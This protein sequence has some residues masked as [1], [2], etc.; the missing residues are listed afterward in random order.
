MRRHQCRVVIAA[1]LPLSPGAA[2]PPFGGKKIALSS[3]T[4][5]VKPST[6][7]TRTAG[8]LEIEPYLSLANRVLPAGP[9]PRCR[10][11]WHQLA[12]SFAAEHGLYFPDLLSRGKGHDRTRPDIIGLSAFIEHSSEHSVAQGAA[13]PPERRLDSWKEIAAFFGRDERTVRRWEKESALPVHRV[14]GGAKGRVFAYASELDLW[15]S[16]P[17]AQQSTTPEP[18]PLLDP[19][20]FNSTQTTNNQVSELEVG[21]IQTRPDPKAEA[22]R[23]PRRYATAA[24]GVAALA[25]CAAL[26]AGIWAYRKNH[27]FA[28]YA[29][30]PGISRVN[31]ALPT[32]SGSE[33]PSPGPDSIA[34]LPF[35]NA[36]ADS[37]TDYL[38]D[39]I[40]ESLIGSL[41]RLPQLKIRSRDSV[42]RYNG[43]DVD[44]Q[45]AGRN[46]NVSALVSGRVVMQRDIVEISAELTDVRNNTELWGHRYTGK[47]A[48]LISLQ[49]QMAGDIAAKLRSTLSAADKEQV[50]NQGTQNAEAYSLYLKGRY[51]WNNRTRPEL[52]KSISYFNQAIARD[53][54]YAL[55]YV[56]L[57]DTYAVL[58]FFNVDPR[59]TFPKSNVA[60]RKALELDSTLAHP[61]AVLGSN[62]MEY[63][64]DFAGGESEFKKS[65]ELDPNDATAHQWYAEKLSL[66]GRHEEAIAEIN[67]AH[68]LDPE[69]LVI[70]RVIGG[71]L[72]DARQYD[73]AIAVCKQLTQD[74]P[75]FAIG[76]DCLF[77]AYW[78]KRMYPQAVEEW[79]AVGQL[80]NNP[81]ASENGNALDHGFHAGGWR[82]AL[83]EV[84]A[85][86]QNRRNH[87]G[88]ASPFEIARF[89]ADRGEREKAFEWLDIAYRE[90]DCLLI[91]LNMSFQFDSIRSD[92]RF[93][94]LVHKVGL[95]Q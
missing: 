71:T 3:I 8:I 6:T 30:G 62:E 82:Q 10:C 93:A 70:D 81:D 2:W 84:I 29:S 76:H 48:D 57:A 21:E 5:I 85:A 95:P 78:A 27:R 86:Q 33:S 90:H 43:K 12:I 53:P 32:P 66:L 80:A 73:Q 16:T 56:G 19:A 7:N 72:T 59:E 4:K 54:Q 18:E 25:I 17:Q 24:M 68:E 88:Y 26:A 64:W 23:N 11:K 92:P 13:N 35:T 74:N 89:Y 51:A 58:H 63:D 44:V 87:G 45:T 22:W 42:F 50:T 79:R 41:A 69:S 28:A 40:T 60:A 9:A 83:A 52:E 55:A 34:V 47:K 67:R 36:G 77:Y 49:Q 14:P 15:L 31:K 1:S 91:G 20:Q 46:L 94:E 38:S 75:T 65:I 39:G 37:K 61:H